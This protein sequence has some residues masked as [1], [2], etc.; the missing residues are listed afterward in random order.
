MLSTLILFSLQLR[1]LYFT[2]IFLYCIVIL[3]TCKS[4]FILFLLSMIRG[5]FLKSF[6]LFLILTIT[7]FSFFT[8]LTLLLLYIYNLIHD[9]QFILT[10]ITIINSMLS[11]SLIVIFRIT[12]YFLRFIDLLIYLTGILL[13][14]I[15]G[16]HLL[17]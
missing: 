1:H 3:Y 4:I 5:I 2:I 8:I 17:L 14:I 16:I 9:I 10:S 11:I 15:T 7:S 12:I 13:L 6:K